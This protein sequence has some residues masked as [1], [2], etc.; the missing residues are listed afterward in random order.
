MRKVL[1]T[2]T[3]LVVLVLGWTGTAAAQEAPSVTLS[4]SDT[5]V[6]VGTAVIFAGQI[7][8]ATEDEPIEL[9]DGAETVVATAVTDAAGAFALTLT[10][11]ANLTLHAV[12]QTV[13]SDPV[14]VKVRVVV[15]ARMT[16]VR[17]FD[18]VDVRGSVR[19]S[20]PGKRV[21][22][23]LLRSGDVVDTAKATIGA[24]GGYETSFRVMEPGTYRARASYSDAQH[25]PDGAVTDAEG[26]PLPSLHEGDHGTFVGLLEQRLVELHYRLT[27]AKDGGYDTRT[28]DA[29]V[30]FRKV[31]GMDR[32]FTVSAPVWRALAD[33][34]EP[35]PHAGGDFH[36]EVDQT[37]QV[38]LGVDGGE[39]TA[40][41]H[42]STGKPS[43]P[44][45]DGGFRVSRKIAGFSPNHLYY[46]SYFDGNRALHGWTDVPTYAASHGCVRI[47]YWNAKWVFR[48][49]PIG[50]RVI[51]YH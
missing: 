12:W 25:L 15:S 27:G 6:V 22:V 21:T 26:T 29:V 38:L 20:L 34:R 48:H 16:P 9:R 46:P 28:A 13:V 11:D 2:G 24:A 47:P 31:Q 37:H 36:F 3:A 51:V 33:P 41:L 4:A 35:D 45:H 30:A 5:K 14:T 7:A 50:T 42:I 1:A 39:V 44:T 32:V 10:P 18:T 43:T 23:T 49:A 19:P 40:I 17:L 8:P